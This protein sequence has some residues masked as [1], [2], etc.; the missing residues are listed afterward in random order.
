MPVMGSGLLASPTM[1]QYK[2]TDSN[3]GS[4]QLFVKNIGDDEVDVTVNKKRLL[5]DNIHLDFSD[6]GIANWITITSPTNFTLKPGESK[7]VSFKITAPNKFDYNDAVGALVIKGVPKPLNKSNSDVPK[8]TIQQ[9]VELVIPIVVGLPGPIIESLQ[10]LEHSSPTVLISF[11]PGDFIYHVKNNG[12]VYA[13]MT[14]NIEINGLLTDHKA[15]I[16][17]GVFPE[18]QYY[19]NTTWEPGFSDFGLY[20]ADTT[21]KYGRYN[22]T[23]TLKTHDTILVIPIWLIILIV[24]AAVIWYI[25][26]K[27]IE[28]PI[29]IKIERK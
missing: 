4:G 15:L 24:L 20:S 14:G 5:K 19:A 29:K 17:G 10:L 26:K 8:V 2:F 23:Q 21:I 3:T 9:A 28:P 1:F 25:R 11:M 22:Q 16:Q 6:N 13:N 12:T 18:D 7:T 27:D